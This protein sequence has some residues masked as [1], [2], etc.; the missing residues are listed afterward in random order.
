MST[1]QGYSTPTESS[2]PTELDPRPVTRGSI[3]AH[4]GVQPPLTSGFALDSQGFKPS[5]DYMTISCEF[6]SFEKICEAI[7]Q[8][9]SRVVVD[10]ERVEHRYYL[11]RIRSQNGFDF[12]YDVHRDLLM[13]DEP[14]FTVSGGGD[15]MKG[16]S[17]FSRSG[18]LAGE[19]LQAIHALFPHV[20]MRAT[21]LDVAADYDDSMFYELAKDYCLQLV[22]AW[23][24]PGRKPAVREVSDCGS[25][26]GNTLYLGVRQKLRLY[27][28]GKQ[29]KDPLRPHW[30]RAE[31]EV[32]PDHKDGQAHAFRLAVNGDLLALWSMTPFS[33]MLGYFFGEKRNK[34]RIEAPK[35]DTSLERRAAVFIKQNW[36]VL[37]DL[38]AHHAHGDWSQLGDIV[39]RLHQA[40][41]EK[42]EWKLNLIS[43]G[44]EGDEMPFS[45]V[46]II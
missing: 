34:L 26:N 23:P 5:L 28:K 1:S 31:V 32:R 37:S 17:S 12:S 2:T 33:C 27:E 13:T 7:S 11:K 24:M 9:I 3:I 41:L 36:R 30:V 8:H 38:V 21:R 29:L 15:H 19:A 45:E 10:G 16:V 35:P 4:S 25:G 20:P 46:R 43:A 39:V 14:L 40:Q 22:E 42:P 6:F 44:D 18:P